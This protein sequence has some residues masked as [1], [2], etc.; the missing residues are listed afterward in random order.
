MSLS[1]GAF[2]DRVKS[3][4]L[5]LRKI[6]DAAEVAYAGRTS[7]RGNFTDLQAVFCKKSYFIRFKG[8]RNASEKKATLTLPYPAYAILTIFRNQLMK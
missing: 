7:N 6:N 2:V 8:K 4:L 3:G 5:Y 1:A